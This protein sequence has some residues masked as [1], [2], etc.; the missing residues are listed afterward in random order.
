MHEIR[1]CLLILTFLICQCCVFPV[2]GDDEEQL[3]FYDI[4][5]A[6]VNG[7]AVYFD[8]EY[9]GTISNGALT[10]R[11]MSEKSR[12]YYRVKLVMDGYQNTTESLPKPAEDLQHVSIFLEMTPLVSQTEATSI[13]ISSS[14][15]GATYSLDGEE[16]GVTP[17]T[18]SDISPGTHTIKIER[19]GYK[20]WTET[21]VALKGET[22]N[23]FASLEK[24]HAFGTISLHSEPEGAEIYLDGWYYGITP[25]TI[26]GITEG[27]HTAELKKD[28]F[29][30]Y[31]ASVTI[32]ENTVTPVTYTMKSAKGSPKKTGTLIFASSPA[33]ALVFIDSVKR[34]T[35]P[36]TVTDLNTDVHQVKLTYEGYQDYLGSVTLSDGETRTFDIPMEHLPASEY[37]PSSIIPLIFSLIAA[38]LPAICRFRKQ[39]EE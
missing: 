17:E 28:G 34:G 39:K 14:P 24:N 8:G 2:M 15:S 18:I 32:I 4:Y 25:M 20:P 37:A 12:P 26:G 10:V 29:T 13:S 27:P 36:V 5:A 22:T 33:G 38:A 3:Y 16:R 30:D 1:P 21:A 23:V 31:T 7:A 6:D 35:T 19:Q 11:V 9:M